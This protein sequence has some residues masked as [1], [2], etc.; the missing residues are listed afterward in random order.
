LASILAVVDFLQRMTLAPLRR[1]LVRNRF[2]PVVMIEQMR[3]PMLDRM[4]ISPP[5]VREIRHEPFL[6]DT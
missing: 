1:M 4:E 3:E 2:A 5:P 6:S